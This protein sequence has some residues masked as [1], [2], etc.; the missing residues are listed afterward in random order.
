MITLIAAIT[1]HSLS[2]YKLKY[3]VKIDDILR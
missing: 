3:N 2:V 1:T